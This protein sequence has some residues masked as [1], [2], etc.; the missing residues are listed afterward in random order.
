MTPTGGQRTY[1][2][3]TDAIVPP[4]APK[5]SID[6]DGTRYYDNGVASLLMG[7]VERFSD[8]G[9][10]ETDGNNMYCSGKS[11]AGYKA[12]TTDEM[13]HATEEAKLE[14]ERAQQRAAD[15]RRRK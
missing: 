7:K 3:P 4:G 10:C 1:T 2:Y 5:S 8:G 9:K 6:V 15:E 13:R 14:E 11:G 12:R